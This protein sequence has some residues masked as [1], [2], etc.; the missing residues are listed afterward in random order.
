MIE[1]I[2]RALETWLRAA[3][4]LP[5]GT[6]DV[7]FD[8]PAA[9]WDARRSIPLLGI[10]L[11][12]LTP[13]RTQAHL[14]AEQ[15]VVAQ[16]DG[17]FVREHVRPVISARYLLG[18]WG[19]GPGVEHELLGRLVDLL[20][21]TLRIPEEHLGDGLSRVRPTPTITLKPDPTTTAASLWSSLDVPPRPSV[22]VLVRSPLAVPTRTPTGPP[23]RQ[24]EIVTSARTQPAAYS[25]RRRVFVRR[26]PAPTP[27]ARDAARI[28]DTAL[29]SD[30]VLRLGADGKQQPHE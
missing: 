6:A 30:E 8:R 13:S 2:D 17:T 7:S 25:V 1:E 24:I 21:T 28:E 26:N 19:G 14:R 12:A 10:F 11:Y 9:D 15:H 4:P 23:P 22:Q 27:G 20:S 5:A 16:P 3:L 29:R 18:V